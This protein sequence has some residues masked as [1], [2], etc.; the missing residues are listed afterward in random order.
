M[1]RYYTHSLFMQMPFDDADIESWKSTDCLWPKNIFYISCQTTDANN[2][3]QWFLLCLSIGQI[4]AK[5][6]SYYK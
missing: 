6:A 4:I 5:V 2:N 1:G 3:Q